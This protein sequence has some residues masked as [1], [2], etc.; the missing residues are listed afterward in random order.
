MRPGGVRDSIHNATGLVHRD[1]KPENMLVTDNGRIL[2]IDLGACADLRM[3]IN[4]NPD[5]GLLDPDYCP[6][7]KLV[8]PKSAPRSG[9]PIFAAL[10][11]P[12]FWLASAPDLFDTYSAGIILLRLLI[13]TLRNSS[14][15]KSFK[16][17]LEKSDDD[18]RTW[19]K[20]GEPQAQNSDFEAADKGLGL[21]WD[22]ACRLVCPRGI[23]FRGRLSAS[24]ALSH[25]F[26]LL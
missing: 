12:L 8:V 21:A 22:L 15:V 16:A 5:E 1:V 23:A 14:F 9:F 3:G 17:E 26:L 24:A 25:P 13:P 18:L 6:P 11:S 7:E 19:R 20:S 10:G 2:M 4:F